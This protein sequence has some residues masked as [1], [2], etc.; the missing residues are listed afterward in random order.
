MRVYTNLISFRSETIDSFIFINALC[1][2]LVSL[3]VSIINFDNKDLIFFVPLIYFIF[4]S[5]FSMML[6][7]NGRILDP[8]NWFLF[9]TSF[10]LGFGVFLGIFNFQEIFRVNRDMIEKINLMNSLSMLVVLTV[11]LKLKKFSKKRIENNSERKIYSGYLFHLIALLILTYVTLNIIFL[12]SEVDI[13]FQSFM[14]NFGAFIPS[15]V[16][17]MFY[18]FGKYN[19]YYKTVLFLI[20]ILCLFY[21]LVMT[22]K[23]Q[24][25]LIMLA[26]L[27][28]GLVK[29]KSLSRLT[30]KIS[31][32]P[33]VY[34]IILIL[35]AFARDINHNRTDLSF[36]QRA[37]SIGIVADSF[38]TDKK[39]KSGYSSASKNNLQPYK[40]VREDILNSGSYLSNVL[41]RFDVFNIQGYLITKYDSGKNGSS[42]DNFW[43][44][45]IPRILWKEKPVVTDMAL[46]L[47]DEIFQNEEMKS[48][49]APTFIAEAYWNY[50]FTGVVAISV[51]IG[52]LLNLF[53][54]WYSDRQ[55][56][57]AFAIIFFPLIKDLSLVESW[58]VPT[59]IAGLIKIIIIY[60]LILSLT[61]V[62]NKFEKQ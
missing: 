35:T 43:S 26:A 10:F 14:N 2:F 25:I 37:S 61:W 16:F 62:L 40:N 60:Y 54:R 56:F 20:L 27:L 58:I 30:A 24:F 36:F 4:S 32:I 50:G 46:S 45:L 5:Y 34:L 11:Y 8:L 17:L 55:N 41:M 18:F 28:P 39:F 15:L 6:S 53:H 48:S 57:F 13:L 9:G 59:Y 51:Y 33:I 47:N 12:T 1:F 3:F 22:T 19:N 38:F 42:L 21:S 49:I 23:L 7:L 31:I 29:N 52:I 44:A